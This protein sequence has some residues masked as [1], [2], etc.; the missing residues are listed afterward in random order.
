MVITFL[1]TEE[2]CARKAESVMSVRW[3]YRKGLLTDITILMKR[4][5]SWPLEAILRKD[6]LWNLMGASKSLKPRESRIWKRR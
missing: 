3:K 6:L 1:M 5:E 4:Q 2:G